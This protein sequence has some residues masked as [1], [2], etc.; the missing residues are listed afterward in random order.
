MK[1]GEIWL[2][3]FPD[4]S[5]REE[6]GIRPVLIL[7]ETEPNVII[8]IPFTSNLF[9]QRFSNTKMIHPSRRNG[10]HAPPIALIFQISISGKERCLRKLGELE[11]SPCREIKKMIKALLD[12]E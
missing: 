10:L 9:A 5:G 4:V 8:V 2:I 12:L 11:E 6:K 3:D 1:R 7:A